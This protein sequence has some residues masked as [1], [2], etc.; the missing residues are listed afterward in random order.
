MSESNVHNVTPTTFIRSIES[1][2]FTLFLKSVTGSS[3]PY[4]SITLPIAG[5]DPLAALELHQ[6]YEEKF[7]WNHPEQSIS[8]SAAGKVREL[9]A[10]G[11]CRFDE[12]SE[13]TAALKDEIDAYTAIEHTMAGPLFL[14]GYSFNHHNSGPVWK[15]FGAARFV[16]PEWMLLQI[17]HLHLLTLNIEKKARAADEIFQEVISR[18]TDFLNLAG[19]LSISSTGKKKQPNILCT[20]QSVDD[21]DKWDDGVK[22]AKIMIEDQR[23]QKIV[24]ARSAVFESKCPIEPTFLAHHLREAYPACYNFMIQ[25]DSDTAFIGATPE[26]LASFNNG[27]FLTE[28]LAGSIS[29]GASA[30]EDATLA[31]LLLRS[32]KDRD[33][34]NYVVEAIRKTLRKYS[35]QVVLPSDPAVKKLKNVQHLFT[36]IRASIRSGVKI[37]KLIEELHPTPAVGGFPRDKAVPYIH[38]LERIDRGWYASPVGWFNLNGCG[39]FAVAIRSALIHKNRAELYAGCGIVSDSDPDIEWDETLMKF[40]PV[41]HAMNQ[42]QDDD[43]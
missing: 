14:G 40:K 23:F 13:Q 15:R 25:P 2:D 5:I 34:H 24:L 39:E 6:N 11:S 27:I 33:E 28:G 21:K 30:L 35:D 22:R 17:G 3:A 43:E 42:L 38:D 8:I 20:H 31:Q 7:Y 12:I 18:I 36:P 19:A 26:R 4:L 29:R 32:G 1:P 10:T 9:K 41:M 37:H 16:L